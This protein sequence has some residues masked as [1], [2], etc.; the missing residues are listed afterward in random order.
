MLVFGI[1][2]SYGTGAFFCHIYLF[3]GFSPFFWWWEG[4]RGEMPSEYYVLGTTLGLGKLYIR[5]SIAVIFF[6][7]LVF[8]F[9]DSCLSIGNKCNSDS[10]SLI[11]KL[12]AIVFT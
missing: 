9:W 6:V 5:Y 12:D 7:I 3:C 2:C 10:K 4:V 11:Y 1:K 8:V